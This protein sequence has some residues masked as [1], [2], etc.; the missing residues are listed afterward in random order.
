MSHDHRSH[1]QFG[2]GRILGFV[3]GGTLAQTKPACIGVNSRSLPR[4]AS[5][6]H[7]TRPHG[8]DKY[9]RYIEWIHLV[10]LPPANGCLRQDP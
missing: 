1:Y 2:C 4:F 8:K 5:G 9:D 3:L 10:Q 6:F 7:P